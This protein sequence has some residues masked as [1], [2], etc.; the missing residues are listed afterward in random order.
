MG[1]RGGQ[2]DISAL[3]GGAGAGKQC[4]YAMKEAVNPTPLLVGLPWGGVRLL[5][6]ASPHKL[7]KRSI[8][9]LVHFE[10]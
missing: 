9:G 5:D 2:V 7:F 6:L 3:V 4:L 8:I 10:T 1:R